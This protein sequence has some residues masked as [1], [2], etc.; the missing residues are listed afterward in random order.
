MRKIFDE[1]KEI[2]FNMYFLDIG[3]GFIG[4]FDVNGNVIEVLFNFDRVRDV[5]DEI[6]FDDGMF[7]GL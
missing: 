2:G 1:V 4:L 6:F 3:G 7:E 5:F